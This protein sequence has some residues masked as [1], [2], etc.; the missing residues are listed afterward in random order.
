MVT[1]SCEMV[2]CPM[3]TSVSGVPA[4]DCAAASGGFSPAWQLREVSGI[5]EKTFQSLA[6]F[7]TP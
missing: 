4:S 3:L 5:G 1:V 2:Q 6:P 7:V